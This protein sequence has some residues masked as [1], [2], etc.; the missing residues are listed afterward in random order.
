MI[1]LLIFQNVPNICSESLWIL[2][3]LDFSHR[4]V[5]LLILCNKGLT[6]G[7][8]SLF[9]ICWSLLNCS[10]QTNPSIK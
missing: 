9:I 1:A 10:A 5:E 6:H 7:W 2:K 3:I 4:V 8:I